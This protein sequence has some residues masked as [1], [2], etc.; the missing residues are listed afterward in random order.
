MEGSNNHDLKV[1][2]LLQGVRVSGLPTLI[3]YWKGQ[4]V[5]SHSG[6]ISKEELDSWLEVHLFSNDALDRRD[7]GKESLTTN[8]EMKTREKDGDNNVTEAT[9][10]RGFVSF[11][12][13]YGKDEYAL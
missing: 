2:M 8:E 10:K 6:M 13:L 5:A 9:S 12:S 4:V 11:T 7:V 1:E 3:L